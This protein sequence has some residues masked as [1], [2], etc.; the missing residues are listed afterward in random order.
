MKTLIGGKECYIYENGSSDVLLI[1]PVDDHDIAV[2][3]SEV[4][5]GDQSYSRGNRKTEGTAL[6]FTEVRYG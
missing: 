4:G 3:D 5:Q 2:L 6:I 1:Q